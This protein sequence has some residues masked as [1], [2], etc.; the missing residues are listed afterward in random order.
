MHSPHRAKLYRLL[1]TLFAAAMA[2]SCCSHALLTG[3]VPGG[4]GSSTVAVPGQ[5]INTYHTVLA[6]TNGG[7]TITVSPAPGSA[8]GD[9]VLVYA[10][11]GASM[12][13]TNS[14]TFGQ[15]IS[16][17]SAGLYSFG[18]V[19]ATPSFFDLDLV[20]PLAASFDLVASTVQMITVPS[21]VNLT[22]APGASLVP[23]A[24]DG[25]TG[26]ILALHA[27]VLTFQD[28]TASIN[29]DGAGSMGGLATAFVSF[30]ECSG[31]VPARSLT[32]AS[33]LF[34]TD[35]GGI[36]TG[37]QKGE[38]VRSVPSLVRNYG[39]G[40]P[41]NGGGGGSIHNSG[42]GGGANGGDS[43]AAWDGSGTRDPTYAAAWL[44][45]EGTSGPTPGGGR[46]GYSWADAASNPA[47][48]PP[49]SCP[50]WNGDARTDVG[51]RGGR[52]LPQTPASRLF[53]GG[54]GG[55]ADGGTFGVSNGGNGGGVVMVIARSIVGPGTISVLGQDG[56]SGDNDGGG[57]GGAGGSVLLLAF[58]MTSGPLVVR[59]DGGRGGDTLDG[60]AC[61]SCS[62]NCMFGPGGGGTSGM[63]ATDD[64]AFG[65][66]LS[67][68]LSGGREGISQQPIASTFPSNGATAGESSTT[69]TVDTATI[70]TGNPLPCHWL[71]ASPS[72]SISVSPSTSPSRSPSASPPTPSSTSSSS[73]SP[74]IT[75]FASTSVSPSVGA[76]S[77]S[78]GTRSPGIT[79]DPSNPGVLPTDDPMITQEPIQPPPP[80]PP[81]P[82]PRDA[83]RDATR[84]GSE[85]DDRLREKA[86]PIA[87]TISTAT[88][89]GC[90]GCAVTAMALVYYRRKKVRMHAH[91]GS[92]PAKRGS[93]K[94]SQAHD[95]IGT[96]ENTLFV[97]PVGAPHGSV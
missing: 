21:Y 74:T 82:P 85:T 73:L 60:S 95:G 9:L 29:A 30:S 39:R 67:I 43:A 41:Y 14:P 15:P 83:P 6:I 40:A 31:V 58:A 97:A 79:R 18:I 22:L 16:L 88:A 53:F 66:Q 17:G 11:N 96:V 70:C 50:L 86:A 89:A 26:G 24:W 61:G 80:P 87:I 91:L 63:V 8:V 12:D 23:Q 7:S 68:S 25:T 77:V 93:V 75:S 52:P 3:F 46:G 37:A 44:A 76:S 92:G 49:G 48:D 47:A 84:R 54:A 62:C 78:G 27:D 69:F 94:E 72:P 1:Y 35:A 5:M 36:Y 56:V 33:A 32:I 64:A 42:G 19:Q 4:D 13:E 59:A 71:V 65:A 28:A 10:S 20:E 55:A 2:L 34:N 57:G 45:L 51:G 90:S 38:G 81:P